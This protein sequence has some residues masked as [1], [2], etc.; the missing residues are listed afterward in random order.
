MKRIWFLRMLTA[1]AALIGIAGIA[2]LSMAGAEAATAPTHAPAAATIQQTA[3]QPGAGLFNG[4]VKQVK[5]TLI[6]H[7]KDGDRQ[8]TVAPGSPVLRNGAAVTIDKLQKGDKIT[9]ILNGQ[10]VATQIDAHSGGTSAGDVLKWL[11]PLIVVVAIVLAAL[12]WFLTQRSE[13]RSGI[14]FGRPHHA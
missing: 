5:P 2:S 14:H 7:A 11:I 13:H 12:W 10:G 3:P 6:V 1:G 9:A 8:I 4:T